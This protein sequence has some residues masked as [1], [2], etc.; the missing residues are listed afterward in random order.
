MIS[1]KKDL[2]GKFA[3]RAE[4][5][6]A[7]QQLQFV[8]AMD[9]YLVVSTYMST[10]SLELEVHFANKMPQLPNGYKASWSEVRSYNPGIEHE[11][12]RVKTFY[13]E[14]KQL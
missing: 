12:M 13:F 4:A 3:T 9:K 14:Y 6:L 1:I 2:G 11:S 7:L 10:Y 5:V 8:F